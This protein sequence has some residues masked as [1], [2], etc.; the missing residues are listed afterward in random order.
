M[1]VALFLLSVPCTAQ[2]A[3][4]LLNDVFQDHVVLQRSE[5]IPV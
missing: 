5:P 2:D 4:P 1:M 3:D